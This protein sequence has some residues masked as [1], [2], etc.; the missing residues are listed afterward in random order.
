MATMASSPSLFM[1]LH[2]TLVFTLL[3]FVT[4]SCYVALTATLPTHNQSFI[5]ISSFSLY[6]IEVSQTLSYSGF[7]QSKLL[8]EIVQSQSPHST[9]QHNDLYSSLNPLNNLKHTS[10][11]PIFSLIPLNLSLNNNTLS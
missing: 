8:P 5:I 7:F 3:G 1:T 4:F 11:S 9:S 10:F 6:H 2:L